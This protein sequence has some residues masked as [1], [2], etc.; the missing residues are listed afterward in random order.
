[1]ATL[2]VANSGG[3]RCGSILP[4]VLE[5]FQFVRDVGSF[6]LILVK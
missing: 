5:I 3:R 6:D 2:G 1:M 4:L